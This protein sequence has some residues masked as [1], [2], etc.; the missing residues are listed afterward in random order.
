MVHAGPSSS[1]FASTGTKHCAPPAF[2][3][4]RQDEHQQQ[5]A[6]LPLYLSQ[7]HLINAKAQQQHSSLVALPPA[8]RASSSTFA[9]APLLKELGLRR[10]AI[11]GLAG[12]VLPS[13]PN[14]V[15]LMQTRGYATPGQVL[16]HAFMLSTDVMFWSGLIGA[17]IFR[18]NLIVM[19]LATEIVMLACNLN[20]LF[21]A[22]YLNDMTVGAKAG[23]GLF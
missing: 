4:Q 23:N 10:T 6:A 13:R 17:V 15:S 20:F 22:A 7:P 8:V 18:R 5:G 14:P 16:G 19:L 1:F 9:S 3:G 11:A 2:Q 12:S 21:A